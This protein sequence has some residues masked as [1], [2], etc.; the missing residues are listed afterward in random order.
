MNPVRPILVFVHYVLMSKKTGV[1]YA[2]SQIKGGLT[3]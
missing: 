1:F 3:G 2:N